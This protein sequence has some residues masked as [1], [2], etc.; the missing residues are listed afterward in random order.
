MDLRA[1]GYC[2]YYGINRV[3]MLGGDGVCFNDFTDITNIFKCWKTFSLHKDFRFEG[4]FVNPNISISLLI[5]FYPQLQDLSVLKRE[6]DKWKEEVKV[7]EA[8][9]CLANSRA[10]SEADAHKETRDQL[11]KT[12]KHLADTRAEI[13]IT[14][15][16]VFMMKSDLQWISVNRA[17]FSDPDLQF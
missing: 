9:A 3:H 5:K 8:K 17:T 13:E 12:I 16:Y 11:E 10:K 2:G 1:I 14:R 4:H 7:Q 6:I 15:K